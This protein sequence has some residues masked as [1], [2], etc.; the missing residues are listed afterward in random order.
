MKMTMVSSG[1]LPNKYGHAPRQR[2]PPASASNS[3]MGG[4]LSSTNKWAPLSAWPS[5]KPLQ[6]L[7]LNREND[8]DN[9]RLPH[10]PGPDHIAPESLNNKTDKF[11]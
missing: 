7:I 9:T 5:S 2:Q 3:D 10:H 11:I 8:F 1:N 6:D 4:L